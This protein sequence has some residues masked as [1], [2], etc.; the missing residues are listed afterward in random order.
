MNRDLK[1]V[2]PDAGGDL[3]KTDSGLVVPASA[4][5][6]TPLK[7]RV[8]PKETVKHLRRFISNMKAESI[9]PV[10]ACTDCGTRITA[11]IEDRIVE[12]IGDNELPGGRLVLQCACSERV[13]R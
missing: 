12:K 1:I 10:L 9:A 11:R 4:V 3:V 5:E 8:I 7:Q 6:P 2:R 13:V